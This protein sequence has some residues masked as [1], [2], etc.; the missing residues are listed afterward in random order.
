MLMISK[1]AIRLP[2]A[3]NGIGIVSAFV[4]VLVAVL[5][6]VS[7]QSLLLSWGA[8]SLADSNQIN[9]DSPMRWSFPPPE[10]AEFSYSAL[11]SCLL[12]TTTSGAVYIPRGC[13]SFFS[14]SEEV[15]PYNTD[16]SDEIIQ[17]GGVFNLSG[18]PIVG[19]VVYTVLTSPPKCWVLN[20]D[21]NIRSCLNTKTR[22]D[23]LPNATLAEIETL[24]R[25]DI[26]DVT[27]FSPPEPQGTRFT[28]L[29]GYDDVAIA[30]SSTGH[31]YVA[32]TPT[33]QI[34]GF[35]YTGAPYEYSPFTTPVDGFPDTWTTTPV[36]DVGDHS[37]LVTSFIASL[38]DNAVWLWGDLNF[39]AP[40]TPGAPTSASTAAATNNPLLGYAS[41]LG[42]SVDEEYVL[43]RA[44]QLDLS[45]VFSTM[46]TW[47]RISAGAG[48]LILVASNGTVIRIHDNGAVYELTHIEAILSDLA[49]GSSSA[50][51]DISSSIFGAHFI[52]SDGS[53]H[54][55]MNRAYADARPIALS[56]IPDDW[57]LD[58]PVKADLG[59]A[60]P[61]NYKLTRIYAKYSVGAVALAAP[62]S[63]SDASYTPLITAPQ[64]S[65]RP[66]MMWNFASAHTRQS[67][68]FKPY[69]W[70]DM[71]HLPAFN[72][73]SKYALTAS[74]GLF[75]TS[76]GSVL[77]SGSGDFAVTPLEKDV[78]WG[79]LHLLPNWLFGNTAIVDVSVGWVDSLA[80]STDGTL[81]AW[82]ATANLGLS[83][84]TR[85]SENSGSFSVHPTEEELSSFSRV[86]PHYA[87]DYGATKFMKIWA[88]GSQFAMIDNNGLLFTWGA[89]WN[90]SETKPWVPTPHPNLFSNYGP[91]LN[92]TFGGPSFFYVVTAGLADDP[93]F[94]LGT[95]ATFTS[96]SGAIADTHAWYTV[97]DPTGQSSL[98]NSDIVQID[99]T[100]NFCLLLSRSGQIYGYGV[101][102]LW[103]GS[104]STPGK[105]DY[106]QLVTIEGLATISARKIAQI[107]QLYILDGNGRL[108]ATCGD[109]LT[110]CA[111]LSR[112]Q[113]IMTGHK[114][115]DIFSWSD[116]SKG[117]SG[118]SSRLSGLFMD[119]SIRLA[120]V[121]P[122]NSSLV[123]QADWTY[124]PHFMTVSL[125]L[126]HARTDLNAPLLDDMDG[127]ASLFPV[128]HPLERNT[129]TLLDNSG[130]AW[131]YTDG[132]FTNGTP[133]TIFS[134]FGIYSVFPLLTKPSYFPR[135]LHD[136]MT[137]SKI[138]RT[139][140]SGTSMFLFYD[141]CTILQIQ[142]SRMGYYT[143]YN[144]PLTPVE[145]GFDDQFIS[146][147][148]SETST[149]YLQSYSHEFMTIWNQEPK[150]C[151]SEGNMIGNV[152]C[153]PL[154]EN[155]ATSTFGRMD[156]S[157]WCAYQ[158]TNGSIFAYAYHFVYISDFCAS[159]ALG[160]ADECLA[161]AATDSSAVFRYIS[162]RLNTS[163]TIFDSAI[164]G[165]ILP[166][167]EKFALGPRHALV[168]TA[169]GRVFGW[170][171]NSVGQLSV[172]P[173]LATSIPHLIELT[174][175]L[176]ASPGA[177]VASGS[178]T[179]L[180]LHGDGSTNIRAVLV[181]YRTSFAILEGN[182]DIYA[183]GDNRY[184][185]LGRGP[186]ST[187]PFDLYDANAARVNLPVNLPFNDFQCTGATCYVLY[188]DGSLYTWG[189]NV[190]NSL[191]R[192]MSS[193]SRVSSMA[194]TGR[195]VDPMPLPSTMISFPGHYRKIVEMRSS[196]SRLILRAILADAPVAPAVPQAPSA[197]SVPSPAITARCKGSPPTPNAICVD[198]VWISNGDVLVGGSSPTSPASPTSPSTP[199]SRPTLT[200]P[201][202]TVI[203]GSLTIGPDAL[204][205]VVL[206]S[207]F[208]ATDPL[209]NVT[210]CVSIEGELQISIDKQTWEELKKKLDGK[211]AL[212][213]E[214]SCGI[215]VSNL[216][217][218]VSTP[219]DCRKVTATSST[220]QLSSG[221]YALSSVFNVDSSKCTEWAIILGSILG[222]VVIITAAIAIG[223]VV[224]KKK[225]ASTATK[226]FRRSAMS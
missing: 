110:D 67:Q 138:I 89:N 153:A 95:G 132:N 108:F 49:P 107:Q 60:L 74:H 91:V 150:E 205:I 144:F 78:I 82:G 146:T 53:M 149:S 176:A 98:S 156:S 47:S 195:D 55:L 97:I 163:N 79:S 9:A 224:Y 65:D 105:F 35:N 196:V 191:A 111:T 17:L 96:E 181:S 8:V 1:M 223:C 139:Y 159:G 179:S 62:I 210:G 38:V 18:L 45:S 11:P 58:L 40:S 114:V 171:K 46:P 92:F 2:R 94:I 164:S 115:L 186:G 37:N 70:Y 123:P 184:G 12:V 57:D 23:L 172:A 106:P 112:A 203:N 161:S 113:E 216:A 52:F 197:T 83:T 43:H 141:N 5:S 20:S 85:A 225:T 151:S 128:G 86:V 135:A 167:V 185:L 68:P 87:E 145:D 73:F 33:A 168:V 178:G 6:S 101:H 208:S 177:T 41:L 193:S 187:T 201:G 154:E 126:N 180:T 59:N 212:L 215:T 140:A 133:R 206:P 158:S 34:L 190:R 31:V 44:V 173:S 25:N 54:S 165:A 100:T 160:E 125:G 117:H 109:A 64:P 4:L 26:V 14:L 202:P 75:L 130:V 116:A 32:T 148:A 80:L 219:K 51:S 119:D 72:S 71:R 194:S 13:A 221:N 188:D 66:L 211:K 124:E 199:H 29:Q 10:V 220:S 61:S 217:T 170:G 121:D 200:I 136:T 90:N 183:W 175:N 142:P 103:F 27:K 147:A 213:V 118:F 24:I 36:F 189:S 162:A 120:I 3:A 81:Y 7:A 19:R 155:F 93:Q 204:V 28:S 131:I 15:P 169:D 102:D 77:S 207:N 39:L 122:T 88:S 157:F 174:A 129:T 50:L 152:T 226:N 21:G 127:Y 63:S 209:L 16:L 99:G 84:Q 42:M 30:L 76:N 134:E 218:T 48:S 56:T 222:A 104:G 69:S 182:T 166:S 22:T 198:G 143:P 214:S 137:P 192:V